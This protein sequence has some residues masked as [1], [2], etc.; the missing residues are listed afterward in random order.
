MHDTI[1]SQKYFQQ[2]EIRY[3]KILDT[4][5]TVNKNYN[6]TLMN[7][8]V[9]LIIIGQQQKGNDILKQLYDKEKDSFRKEMLASY[10]DKSKQEILDYYSQRK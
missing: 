10:M 6:N 2:S 4:M 8:G 1:S 3:E 7:K 5:N 9:N